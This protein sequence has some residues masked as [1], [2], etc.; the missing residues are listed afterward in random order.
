[1]KNKSRGRAFIWHALTDD[2]NIE[3]CHIFAI[4]HN[5]IIE[6]ITFFLSGL[7]DCVLE[8]SDKCECGGGASGAVS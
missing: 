3:N 5:Y 1:M 8:L 6:I 7:H 4:V 2:K